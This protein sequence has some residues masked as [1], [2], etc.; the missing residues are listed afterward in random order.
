MLCIVKYNASIMGSMKGMISKNFGI[1]P[2]AY[3]ANFWAYLTDAY[4]QWCDGT[5]HSLILSKS[6]YIAYTHLCLS[7]RGIECYTWWIRL[8]CWKRDSM[9]LCFI[10]GY[11]NQVTHTHTYIQMRVHACMHVHMH[12]HTHTP[13][14]IILCIMH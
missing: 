5:C 11:Y 9:M 12:T 2:K 1:F 3:W 13:I 7:Y 8:C 6:L 14:N 10:N 4:T